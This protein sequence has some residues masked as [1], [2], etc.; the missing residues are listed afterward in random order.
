[1][2]GIFGPLLICFCETRAFSAADTLCTTRLLLCRLVALLLR[3]RRL[4]LAGHLV[5]EC[6]TLY[7]FRLGALL[8]FYLTDL[9]YKYFGD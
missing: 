9:L 2:L 7:I 6:G 8:Q 5:F 4:V 3:L 1:M